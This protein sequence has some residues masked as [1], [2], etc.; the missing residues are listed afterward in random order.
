M[1]G[2]VVDDNFLFVLVVEGG[3]GGDGLDGHLV[4]DLEGLLEF[5]DGLGEW[6]HD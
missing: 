5:F 4:V 3:E 1:S 6:D 2:L